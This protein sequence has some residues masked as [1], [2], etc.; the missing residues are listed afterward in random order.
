MPQTALSNNI[1]SGFPGYR[2]R[3]DV[4]TLKP[5]VMV[6]G[7]KNV[8]TNTYSRVGSRKG[9]TLDGQRGTANSG[10]GVYGSYDWN[11]HIGTERNI[12]VGSNTTGSDGKVQVRYVA[13]AGDTY[14]AETFV[15]DEVYWIDIKTDAGSIFSA[16]RFWDFSQELK[17]MLLWV[18]GTS[19][20]FMW[21]GAISTVVATSWA[22]GS[23][24][25]IVATPTAA[26]TGYAVND[27]LT[28]TTG[29]TN[30]TVKVT[31]I[32]GSGAVTSVSLVT[33]GEGYTTGAGKVTSGGGGTGCTVEISTVVQGYIKLNDDALGS[34]GFMSA[35]FW[36]QAV[37]IDGTSYTYTGIVGAYLVGISAD[38]TGEP[39][40]EVAFQ[41]PVTKSN[42]SGIS[43][44]PATFKNTIIENLNNQIYVSASDDNSVY[45]SQVNTFTAYTFSSPR[46]P[47]E[48]AIL[49]LDGV[50]SCIRQQGETM[51]ISAK[52]DYWYLI[53]LQPSADLINESVNVIP[54]KTTSKQGCQANGLSTKI[55][56]LI[57]FVSRETQINTIGVSANYFDEPQVNDISSPIVHD[58]QNKDFT[59][60][61]VLFFQKYIFITKPAEGVMLIYNMTLDLTETLQDIGKH[62]WETPQTLPFGNLSIIDGALYGHAYNETNTFKL[63]VGLSDDEKPYK[64]AALFA[65]DTYGDRADDKSSNE[66]FIEGY[67]YQDTELT[68]LLRRE[69]N[70]AVS[71]WKFKK[72]PSRCLI[73]PL[74]DSS[75]GKAPIGKSPIGGTL[76]DTDPA[77]PPKFRLIQTYPR[78]PFF[79]EQVGFTSEGVGQWWEIVSFA[80]NATNTTE[81][82]SSIKDPNLGELN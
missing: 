82:Q 4:A 29:G 66:F 45:I 5:D 70:G 38:P 68:G 56:N 71:S 28:I 43:G 6:V 65:Y 63:F 9:Y 53:K 22:T 62:Y 52:E 2:N 60:G 21:S 20:I 67:K 78:K 7:S 31:A 51:F 8:L 37:T 42:A 69:L 40:Q 61:Q 32:G 15:E 47:G 23:V 81:S 74:D 24:S 75:I 10:Y 48:G 3:E 46:K 1:R 58:V 18:D 54:L 64:C 16:C 50:P 76:E 12:R 73:T 25:A 59:G 34:I 33:P 26:G 17:D 79:E 19:N 39:V 35:G 77:T 41:T 55:K 72:L 30:A 49:T 14:G 13:N 27:V 44:L 36:T 11:T 57:A 80:T